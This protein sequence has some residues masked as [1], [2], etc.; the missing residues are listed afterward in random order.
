MYA[1]IHTYVHV[2]MQ[3]MYVGMYVYIFIYIY[4]CKRLRGVGFRVKG[5]IYDGSG[6]RASA[7]SGLE[8]TRVWGGFRFLGFWI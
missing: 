5:F 3:G 7:G 4:L 8:A 2:C 1:Y 6:F